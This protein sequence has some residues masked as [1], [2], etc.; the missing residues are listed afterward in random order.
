MKFLKKKQITTF[1]ELSNM[2]GSRQKPA[3]TD[4]QSDLCLHY[5]LLKLTFKKPFHKKIIYNDV[6]VIFQR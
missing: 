1:R 2:E 5:L 4:L 6:L 3:C